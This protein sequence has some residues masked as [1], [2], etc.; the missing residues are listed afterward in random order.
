[1]NIGRDISFPYIGVFQDVFVIACG[2]LIGS[3]LGLFGPGLLFFIIAIL[4]LFVGHAVALI[5]H[6][7]GAAGVFDLLAGLVV[8]SVI[9]FLNLVKPRVPH[10][11]TCGCAGEENDAADQKQGEK[12]REKLTHGSCPPDR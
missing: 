10:A 5:A 11:D 1:M 9:D 3:H 6:D 8:R 2:G 7:H 12:N 4:V